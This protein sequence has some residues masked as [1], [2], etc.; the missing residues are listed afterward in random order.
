MK[1]KF[2]A[3]SLKYEVNTKT[4]SQITTY[5]LGLQTGALKS[6]LDCH[7]RILSVCRMHKFPDA[8][9]A[10]CSSAMTVALNLLPQH[11]L[12]T[13]NY[14]LKYTKNRQDR[15]H[16]RPTASLTAI[17]WFW[18]ESCAVMCKILRF[19]I[20]LGACSL[21]RRS[22]EHARTECLPIWSMSYFSGREMGWVWSRGFSKKLLTAFR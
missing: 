15:H 2:L 20:L 1:T 9:K 14:R 6:K 12:K 4:V 17:Q 16:K 22:F 21:R 3:C 8:L 5:F 18:I 7:P 10:G 19:L 11:P 13:L